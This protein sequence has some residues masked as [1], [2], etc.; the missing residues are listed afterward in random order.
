MFWG[1]FSV[2]GVG[3]LHPCDGS[4]DSGAYINIL[5]TWLIPYAEAWFGQC[6]WTLL[7]DNAPCHNSR[8]TK[9]YL[10]QSGIDVMVWP[11]N[12]PDLNPIEN[13]WGILKQK[14]LRLGTLSKEDLIMKAQQIWNS[15]AMIDICRELVQSMPQRVSD[16]IDSKGDS[17]GY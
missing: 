14:L 2:L 11:A 13:L 3:A 4:V 6:H 15:D 7:Q 9:E 17:I 12:S 16:V 8:A 1:S 10:R 5:D